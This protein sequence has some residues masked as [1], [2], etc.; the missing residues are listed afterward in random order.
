MS[1]AGCGGG[2]TGRPALQADTPL[3]PLI[4]DACAS[5]RAGHLEGVAAAGAALAAADITAVD[6]HGGRATT[7]TD[8]QGRYTLDVSGLRGPLVVSAHGNL[9]G[10][11]L[12]F[13]AV[14]LPAEVGRARTHL[15]PFSELIAA[16]VLRGLPHDLLQQARADLRH[17][18]TPVVRS[19]E[20]ELEALLKP[21]L[22]SAGVPGAVDLRGGDFAADH[23]GLDRALDWLVFSQEDG[24]YRLRHLLAAPADAVA[25][26]AQG[27]TEA[28]ALPAPSSTALL[29]V[30]DSA[31]PQIEA[32][33]MALTAAYAQAVPAAEELAPW[34]SSDFLHEGL[35]ATQY[36]ARIL[37]QQ[38]LPDAGGFSLRGARWD[39][40]RVVQI[41][42]ADHL[43]V[44]FR[45]TPRAPFEAF[46]Q[47][48]WMAR[49]PGGWSWRGDRALAQVGVRQVA[50][51]G[52]R[53]LTLAQVRALPGMVCAPQAR[54]VAQQTWTDTRCQAASTDGTLD[55]GFA[56][57][58]RFGAVAM[59]QSSAS[60]P[61]ERRA[62][63]ARRSILLGTPS[64]RVTSYLRF[65]VDR[66]RIDARVAEVRI[67][68][69]GLPAEGL[70][71]APPGDDA[72]EAT[73]WSWAHHPDDDWPAVPMGWCPSDDTVA[74]A[75]CEDAWRAVGS[76]ATYRFTLLD[77]NAQVLGVLQASSPPQPLPDA[78]LLA[79]ADEWF[80]RFEIDADSAASPTL[81]RVLDLAGPGP[82]QGGV[83]WAL[84]R[85][86]PRI[87]P[88]QPVDAR[89]ELARRD[90]DDHS[91]VLLRQRRT[92]SSAAGIA[93]DLQPSWP[94]DTSR[95][96]AW[97][98]ARL[99]ASDRWGNHY[100]HAVAP[101]N[102]R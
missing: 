10:Q 60:T 99:Q 92:V 81:A 51:L 30:A 44:R 88:G 102:P 79:R 70:S 97:A 34:L 68:G 86:G 28:D 52:P 75:A 33:L 41:A 29:G 82:H 19:A 6:G 67:T 48:L 3:E 13:Q 55:A 25:F 2:D 27:D 24:G 45:V 80:A 36:M 16:R 5:C 7:R 54:S 11:A 93:D 37:R 78:A 1:L 90:D 73:H 8:A 17:I 35:G 53:P 58:A 69:P 40:P 21:L 22:A 20:A 83:G 101:H 91:P 71:L 56:G 100:V 62:Q 9:N 61:A 94:F 47:T 59:F 18:T 31:L 50:V 12:A 98:S 14:V 42:D 26:D 63:V 87:G 76:G 96:T 84:P 49:T 89:F 64:A 74:R 38:D 77:A 23:T 57:D 39:Q 65:D 15:T 43:L 46:S 4:T 72:P 32:R 95:H 66:R 85:Q